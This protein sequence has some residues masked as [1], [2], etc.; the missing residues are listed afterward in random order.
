MTIYP[1]G[2]PVRW[3]SATPRHGAQT[4]A[5]TSTWQR[6]GDYPYVRWD[7]ESQ[8]HLE[9]PECVEPIGQP[10]Q[11]GKPA[12]VAVGDTSLWDNYRPVARRARQ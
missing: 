2:H 12:P 11:E 1:I 7:G 5:L 9:L 3:S 6:I 8:G 10:T 4:G